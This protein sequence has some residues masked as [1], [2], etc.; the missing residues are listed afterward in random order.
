MNEFIIDHQLLN[1]QELPEFSI[2]I[3]PSTVTS[4]YSDAEMQELLTSS[5]RSVDKVQVFDY[6]DNLYERL[7]VADNVRFFGNGLIVPYH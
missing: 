2:T 7:T 6:E 5:F 3:N 4:I 1:N